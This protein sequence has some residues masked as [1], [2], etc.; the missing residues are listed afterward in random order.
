VSTKDRD[1]RSAVRG[2]SRRTLLALA[3]VAGSRAAA[4]AAATPE[5]FAIAPEKRAAWMQRWQAAILREATARYCDSVLGEEIGWLMSPILGGFYE[6][7]LATG[8]AAWLERLQD[9]TDAWAARA[10]TEPDGYPGWPKL[11]AAG[12]EVDDLDSYVADSLLG[13]AMALRPIVLAAAAIL[14]DPALA[15]RLGAKARADIA[16]AQRVFDKW[17]ARGAWRAAGEGM[18]T[19]VLPYGIDPK[20]G[21]WAP[22]PPA[23]DDLHVGFSHPDNKANFVAQWLLAMA[24]ATGEMAYRDRA[25]A[26][27]RLMR[28]RMHP[29]DD[30]TYQLWNYWEPAGPWDYRRAGTPKHWVGVHRNTGYYV[31]DAEAI[32]TAH[33]H[34]VVFTRDDL[35]RLIRTAKVSGRDWPALAPYDAT[36]RAAFEH[37][38]D[39]DGWEGLTFVPWYVARAAGAGR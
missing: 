12:T 19:V 1:D 31:I 37:S 29:R 7:Y 11:G 24:D 21:R 9:W 28:G 3:A 30:G 8:D 33:E 18:I 5:S 27:F 16:L 38:L 22:A 32:V 2:L 20:T 25:A 23:R 13:E 35:D 34:G 4:A 15:G 36:L 6:G 10:V 17:D 14:R 39:P 26:W